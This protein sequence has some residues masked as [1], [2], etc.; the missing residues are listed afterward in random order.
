ML[1]TKQMPKKKQTKQTKKPAKN[2]GKITKKKYIKTKIIGGQMIQML[3]LNQKLDFL[4]EC[5]KKYVSYINLNT[6]IGYFLY[7]SNDETIKRPFNNLFLEKFKPHNQTV[8]DFIGHL[9]FI[10]LCLYN[11][12]NYDSYTLLKL[13]YKDHFKSDKNIL[14]DTIEID[15]EKKTILLA[16]ALRYYNK[17]VD[18]LNG[19]INKIISVANPSVT[20]AEA[21][22]PGGALSVDDPDGAQ[23]GEEPRGQGE[24]GERGAGA[25]P[26]VEE[27]AAPGPP[28]VQGVEEEAAGGRQG[29]GEPGGV[30]GEALG[31]GG[32]RGGVFGIPF[33]QKKPNQEKSEKK[34]FE[35]SMFNIYN[36]GIIL[37]TIDKDEAYYNLKV[38]KSIDEKEDDEKSDER[39]IIKFLNDNQDSLIIRRYKNPE[40]DNH[41]YDCQ[42]QLMYK[43]VNIL[44]KNIDDYKKAIQTQLE[45]YLKKPEFLLNYKTTL[46]DKLIA[47]IF[48]KLPANVTDIKYGIILKSLKV[49]ILNNK[50]ID[51]TYIEKEYTKYLKNRN[52]EDTNIESIIALSKD[53]MPTYRF[54]ACDN[55]KEYFEHIINVLY[56]NKEAESDET[57]KYKDEDVNEELEILIKLSASASPEVSLLGKTFNEDNC[58]ITITGITR[59]KRYLISE[60]I[61]GKLELLAD[62]NNKYMII[63]DSNKNGEIK[64]NLSDDELNIIK[65]Y[66]KKYRDK[67]DNYINKKPHEIAKDSYLKVPDEMIAIFDEFIKEYEKIFKP[68][69]LQL[70]KIRK[71]KFAEIS[72]SANTT[73]PSK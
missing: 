63:S 22:D 8:K 53:K 52:I 51:D 70:S 14:F 20:V 65:A 23:G 71:S 37:L 30:E 16:D 54:A 45:T 25:A 2:D 21:P 11:H 24:G 10:L 49:I 3:T 62:Y 18:L 60:A 40:N 41:V 38:F 26:R 5:L 57:E 4:K 61:I 44:I 12:D 31:G 6:G 39:E 28:L 68:Y 15:E 1:K 47:I 64:P 67:I 27:G 17:Y 50:G 9:Q 19:F 42:I 72:R 7:Y 66:A 46:L 58:R 59:Y 35:T 43:L 33:T 48:E 55:R 34:I 69:K 13:Y 29:G 32:Q 73:L 36:D 56:T